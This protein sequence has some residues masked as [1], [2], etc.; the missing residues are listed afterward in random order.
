MCSSDLA[1]S[2]YSKSRE[3]SDHV[4]KVM[5]MTRLESG[6]IELQR[7]WSSLPELVGSVLARL[8]ERLS[9]HKL[10]LEISP[11]LPLA[12][13]DAA[14]IEQVLTNLLENAARHTPE[15]TI[16][17]VRAPLNESQWDVSV[18]DF[19]PGLKD[20]DI[21]RVFEKF[22]RGQREGSVAGVG[23]GLAI[24]R[25]IVTLHGGHIWAE[26][27]PHGGTIFQFTIPVKKMPMSFGNGD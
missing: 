8:E 2:I 27:N 21:D 18:E 1:Q 23:L 15:G 20:E 22:Y 24:C 12:H 17:R 13:V 9:T 25:A 11:D 26:A 5:Q 3:L 7:E 14:L 6:G 16:I 19:G 4:E 10:L